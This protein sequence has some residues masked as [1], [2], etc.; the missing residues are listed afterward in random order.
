MKKSLTSLSMAIVLI[1]IVN[2]Q[3][4]KIGEFEDSSG[5][6]TEFMT[7]MN[8]QYFAVGNELGIVTVMD[9]ASQKELYK[10]RPHREPVKFIRF[11][12]DKGELITASEE[13]IIF[14]NVTD[15]A[16]R[17]KISIFGGIEVM[18]LN[19][20]TNQVYVLAQRKQIDLGATKHIYKIDLTTR[21]FESVHT[22]TG[23][24]DFRVS[25]D[26]KMLYIA[27]G[28]KI[29]LKNISLSLVENELQSRDGKDHLDIDLAK[30]DWI[31][32]NDKLMARYWKISSGKSYQLRWD[33]MASIDETFKIDQVWSLA[34][35]NNL[36]F[37]GS[38]GLKIR[39]IKDPN[40]DLIINSPTGLDIRQVN[41][42]PDRTKIFV[43]ADRNLVEVWSTGDS[44]P[45]T[46]QLTTSSVTNKVPVSIDGDDAIYAKYKQEIDR[47]LDLRAELFAPRGEFERSADYEKR[48]A[49]AKK[50]KAGVFD[51]Y[52]GVANR[53]TEVAAELERA[54]LRIVA[55]KRREDSVRKASLYK[56]KIVASY[57]EF[58]TR[59]TSIGT[60]NPDREE[61]PI[62]IDEMT[63]LVKV[64][65]D[66]AREF[67]D[68]SPFYRVVGT[69]QLL[70]DAVTLDKFNYKIITDAGK[71]F[72]FGKQK[73]ALFV[74]GEHKLL[75]E[76]LQRNTSTQSA[77]SVTSSTNLNTSS[78]ADNAPNNA[79]DRAI[80]NYFRDKKY[81]ALLI[82]VND[83]ADTRI[84]Q[85]DGPV[86]DATR[87]KEVLL[88]KYTFQEGNITFLQNPT[89]TEI[90][91][92]FDK[93]QLEIG[94][95]DNLL[96]FYAGH[97]IWDE[98]LK[99]GF[100]LPSN[101]KIDS[102]AEWLSN[103]RIRDYIG[104]INAKHT[105]LVA[106][107]CFSGGIFKT[108]DVFIQNRASLELAKLP[109][110]KAI[111][112]GAMKTVP[113]KSVFIEYLIK[114]LEQNENILL[115]TEQL[116]SSFKIAV[117]NN[118]EGQVP[119]YG[120]IQGA[121]DEGGDFVFLIRR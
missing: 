2:G 109:S 118:S 20:P 19:A 95:K 18:E 81:H 77:P 32:S 31:V 114:R 21:K 44:K 105:L 64:P 30:P 10:I 40:S 47:E 68:G 34:K 78:K 41:V 1:S 9:F 38:K 28:S 5:E 51:Y 108:R 102:K 4:S 92:T 70:E 72:S 106:D 7:D 61:F 80:V 110:R 75:Q 50:Y 117:M 60:Y 26:G 14:S 91:E 43:K 13:E 112:S 96:V 69:K 45:T 116:F 12:A 120:D 27:K 90:I 17:S 8:N 74:T 25:G 107:A 111:T 11:N 113:D 6:P 62:T 48:K 49:D 33:A 97:G 35:E 65:F 89:R 115:P 103:A 58:Y 94:D 76:V 3:P 85:L 59:I 15:G 87:L 16:Q 121:G 29:L 24:S 46:S 23:V 71:V 54:R 36:L 83:Y 100:W 53:E 88:R 63:H 22:A 98:N 82:A 86:K 66:E 42:S 79:V 73:R 57:E 99:Q 119:Q 56:D 104:G 84:T 39:D 67:K 93:L 52:K 55:E 101:S 37:F